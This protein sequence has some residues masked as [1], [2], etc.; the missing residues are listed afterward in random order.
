M[1]VLSPSSHRHDFAAGVELYEAAIDSA[2]QYGFTN[3]EALGT[4]LLFIAPHI[5]SLTEVIRSGAIWNILAHRSP[6]S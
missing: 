3:F 4:P 2:R 5:I 6:P 1:E